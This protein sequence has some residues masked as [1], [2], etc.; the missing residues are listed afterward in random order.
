MPAKIL[1][2][3]KVQG[4]AEGT[5]P[6][7]FYVSWVQA[8]KGGDRAGPPNCAGAFTQQLT[9]LKR[10]FRNR[11]ISRVVASGAAQQQAGSRPVV[12]GGDSDW[13]DFI[14]LLTASY[15]KAN[16]DP[17]GELAQVLAMLDQAGEKHGRGCAIWTAEIERC[18]GR[19]FTIAGHQLGE[20]G[21]CHWLT[22]DRKPLASTPAVARTRDVN[23]ACEKVLDHDPATC[24]SCRSDPA[25]SP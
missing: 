19:F 13:T 1:D 14:A 12:V 3:G 6:R 22:E 23:E 17:G 18:F 9:S 16:D 21:L 5:G 8:A 15:S 25:P 10:D 4:G 24:H 11:P 2:N 20:R 7:N